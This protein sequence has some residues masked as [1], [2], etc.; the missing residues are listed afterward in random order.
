M[1]QINEGR[2][3]RGSSKL[4]PERVSRSQPGSGGRAL[5]NL[6]DLYTHTCV[7]GGNRGK[8][9]EER[10]GKRATVSFTAPRQVAAP[11]ILSLPSKTCDSQVV[12]SKVMTLV[13]IAYTAIDS[14]SFSRT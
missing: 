6:L 5:Q 10:K 9:G 8:K 13:A 12:K 1:I 2:E 11:R 14:S 3:K 7:C 4:I